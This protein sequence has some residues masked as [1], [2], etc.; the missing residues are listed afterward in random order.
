MFIPETPQ[1]LIQ[2]LTGKEGQRALQFMQAYHT[3]VLA[4]VT[5][6]KGGQSVAGV[7]VYNTV[8]EALTH[9]PQINA[10]SLYVPP[11]FVKTAFL[12]LTQALTQFKLNSPFFVHLIAEGIPLHDAA[13]IIET[14]RQ[15]QL[16]LL[17]PSS[18]GLIKPGKFKL[19]SIG[20]LSNSSFQPGQIAVLSKSGGLSSEVSL[21]LKSAG[22]GQSLVAG[23]GGDILIGSAFH[24][25]FSYLEQDSQT[26]LVILVGEVG[27]T[28]EQQAATALKQGLLTK[29]VIAF[30]SGLFTETLPQGVAL[31]HAGALIEGQQSTRQAKLTALQ[32]AGAH[33]ANSLED[34]LPL[35]QRLL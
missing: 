10:S 3:S 7:P 30:V 5:P 29:P 8:A 12:E 18:I 19:G 4:G 31:G 21:I 14:A 24:D 2:G 6:G 22:L 26:K 9:H 20:G 32:Q 34:I 27:G 15:H 33:L 17:G 11:R 28:Y 1:L 16:T 35:V 13:F 25:F 23:I